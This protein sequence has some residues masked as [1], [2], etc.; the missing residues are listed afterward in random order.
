M[1]HCTAKQGCQENYPFTGS[2][3]HKAWEICGLHLWVATEA[4]GGTVPKIRT[5][6]D[7]RLQHKVS[8]WDRTWGQH[9][10]SRTQTAKRSRKRSAKQHRNKPRTKQSRFRNSSRSIGEQRTTFKM[11]CSVI[12]L[13]GAKLSTSIL[14]EWGRYRPV[15]VQR[16]TGVTYQK[17]M[18]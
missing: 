1:K 5:A 9:Q 3:K 13:A 11:N 10:H 15:E 2:G 18:I 8:P 14:Q 17:M 6:K 12:S 16:T 4:S 7:R